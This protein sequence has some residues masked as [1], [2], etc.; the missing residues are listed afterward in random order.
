M[1]ISDRLHEATAAERLEGEIVALEKEL[2]VATDSRQLQVATWLRD[3]KQ[4]LLVRAR[5]D[6]V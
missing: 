3:R 5:K 4:E 2:A 6:G 1:P